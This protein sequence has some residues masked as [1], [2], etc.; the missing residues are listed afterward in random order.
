EDEPQHVVVDRLPLLLA[1]LLEI[2]GDRPVP[3]IEPRSPPPA[4]DRG[5]CGHSSEPGARVARDARLRPLLER[6]NDGLLSELLSQ[7]DVARHPRERRNDAW[8]LDA[9]D[10]IDGAADAVD[11][12]HGCLRHSR[13]NV[14]P[15]AVPSSWR[16]PSS[17]LMYSLSA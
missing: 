8:A 13:G 17:F 11:V 1:R 4:V 9:P 15:Q 16:Q 2:V 12:S 5:A 3:L 6:V 7:P 14:Q 10:G